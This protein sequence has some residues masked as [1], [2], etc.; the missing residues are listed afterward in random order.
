MELEEQ[1]YLLQ[2]LEVLFITVVVEAVREA[3]MEHFLMV[4]M[5]VVAQEMRLEQQEQQEQQ[6]QVEVV[7]AVQVQAVVV[8]VRQEVQGL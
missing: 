1:D 8:Q 7:E 4:E 3:L 5:A 6:T 2:L